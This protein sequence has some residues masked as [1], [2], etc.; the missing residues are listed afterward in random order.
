MAAGGRAGEE[1]EASGGSHRPGAGE[2]HVSW[3][4]A[5]STLYD[6]H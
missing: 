4:R 1:G 5:W 3:K 6:T 2:G